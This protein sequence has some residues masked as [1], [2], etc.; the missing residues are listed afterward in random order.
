MADVQ[1]KVPQIIQGGMGAAVSNWRLAR[2]VSSLG[3][4]GVVSG[5]GLDEIFARRLQNGDPGGHIRNALEHF[6]F[7]GMKKRIL[8]TLYVPGGKDP[9]APYQR[10]E[11]HAV[12]DHHWPQALCIAA[13]FV[14]VF[15]AR[16]GHGNPVG[17]NYLEK[18]QLP[19]L[20]SLYGAMLAG[21]AVVIVGAGVP[22]AIPAAIDALASHQ[23]A[24]YPIHVTGTPPGE[25]HRMHFDPRDFWEG[26]DELAPLERPH[27]LPI[28]SSATLATMLH[29]RSPDGISGFVIEGNVAGG[30][31]APPRG[32]LVLSESGEPVYGPRDVVN[33]DAIKKLGLPFW[34]AGAYGS[35]EKLEEAM[36]HGAAGIQ[37]GTAFALCVESGMCPDHRRA[38]VKKALDGKGTI[39]TDPLA[40]PTG[41]PFKVASLAGTLSDPDVYERRKRFCDLGFLREPYI[42]DDGKIGYR[43]PAEPVSAYVAKGG[44]EE[45]TVGRKCLCN[46]LLGVIGLPQE[47]ADG[48]RDLA[49]ITLGDAYAD[50]PRFCTDGQLDYTAAHVIDVLLG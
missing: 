25:E 3:Q 31:N 16:E 21:V 10:L 17:I 23:P 39:F 34:L 1:A 36:D 47:F 15:M 44:R 20:P 30:H 22:I 42:R 41:F 33:L 27:F 2:A 35:P 12:E 19:H 32:Q 29:R 50:I 38:L 24:T 49:L 7:Q 28:I 8:D 13:N 9:T 18:I 37:V 26:E 40:S 14:E 43:C 11:M 46:A 6:P 45:D 5:T 4:L 48:T